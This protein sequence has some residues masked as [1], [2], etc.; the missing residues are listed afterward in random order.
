MNPPRLIPLVLMLVVVLALDVLD[1]GESAVGWMHA[2]M[3]LGGLVGGAVAASV[4]TST[5]LGR[6][7]VAG[8]ALWGAPLI[9]LALVP[10]PLVAFVALGI[11]GIGNAVEV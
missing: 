4:V 10:T 8:V 6:G 1:I 9:V 2:S 11:V 5:R 3:A 7:F